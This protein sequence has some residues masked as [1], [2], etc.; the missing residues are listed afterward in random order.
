MPPGMK[1]QIGTAIDTT[2][3][4]NAASH[5]RR[6]GI[7]GFN[8]TGV[9][10]LQD[11]SHDNGQGG[12]YIADSP[13][14][15]AVVIGNRS[16]R[17]AVEEGIGLFFRDASHGV[18]RDNDVRANCVGIWFLD[19]QQLGPVTASAAERERAPAGRPPHHPPGAGTPPRRHP[20]PKAPHEVLVDGVSLKVIAPTA[21]DPLPPWS[22]DEPRSLAARQRRQEHPR[23]LTRAKP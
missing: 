12:F 14:T 3:S 4:H 20:P 15:N 9:R 7:A 21:N 6:W 19:A 1:L 16:F 17:N 10:Y 8:L 18:V 22:R 13:D 23:H 11:V 5:N 2:I